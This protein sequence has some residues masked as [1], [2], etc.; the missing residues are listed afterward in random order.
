MSEKFDPEAIAEDIALNDY[1]RIN[2]IDA[3]REAHAAGGREKAEEIAAEIDERSAACYRKDMIASHGAL[4]EAAEIARRH[5]APPSPETREQR[6]EKALREI[7]R[8][9]AP[10]VEIADICRRALEEK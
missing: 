8:G 4:R 5:A 6:L 1:R 9:T 7:Q 2:L 3:L 10:Q